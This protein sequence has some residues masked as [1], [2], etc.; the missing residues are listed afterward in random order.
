MVSHSRLVSNQERV[1]VVRVPYV[2]IAKFWFQNWLNLS[3]NN[4]CFN[5][6]C[7]LIILKQ[8]IFYKFFP[9][10]HLLFH[11]IKICTI[12]N[13]NSKQ[14]LTPMSLATVQKGEKGKPTGL[15][16]LKTG[17]KSGPKSLCCAWEQW[18]FVF[19]KIVRKKNALQK[20]KQLLNQNDCY[21]R[22]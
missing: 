13:S 11:M 17:G 4:F 14:T 16:F 5:F 10:Y 2:K 8:L 21:W 6:N 9:Y 3:E 20:I 7:H 22:F 15:W 18:C 12:W 19:S 1:I